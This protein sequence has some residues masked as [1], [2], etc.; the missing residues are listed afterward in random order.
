MSVLTYLA[1]L[2][3]LAFR[4]M[5]PI[6]QCSLTHFGVLLLNILLL[7]LVILRDLEGQRVPIIV[8]K[9]L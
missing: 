9:Y 5:T 4:L 8:G 6:V 2:A 3:D 1:Q 7:S